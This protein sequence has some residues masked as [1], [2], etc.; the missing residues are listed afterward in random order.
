MGGRVNFPLVVSA[1]GG[2]PV[3]PSPLVG[4]GAFA[5]RG[6]V[7]GLISVS[8]PTLT[9]LKFAS[10]IFA[11]LSHKGRGEKSGAR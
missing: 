6:R 11:T 3:L 4:E 1:K 5:K 7:R 2:A 8:P 9:R 10:L